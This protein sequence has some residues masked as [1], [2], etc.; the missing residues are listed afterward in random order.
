MNFSRTTTCIFQ[1]RYFWREKVRNKN[2]NARGHGF[3]PAENKAFFF[4]S[5]GPHFLSRVVNSLLSSLGGS[6]KCR[7]ASQTAPNGRSRNSSRNS[8]NQCTTVVFSKCWA[9]S[10]M[11]RQCGSAPLLHEYD[12][13]AEWRYNI[14]LRTKLYT[15]H[16]KKF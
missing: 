12:L 15:H 2:Q 13:L 10:S 7:K 16:R 9:V 11:P 14:I 5:Y 4:A 6:R 1:Y 8:Q 3:K